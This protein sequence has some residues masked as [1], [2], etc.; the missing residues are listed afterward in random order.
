[1]EH[2]GFSDLNAKGGKGG[3]GAKPKDNYI[4]N[5]LVKVTKQIKPKIS[6]IISEEMLKS[7]N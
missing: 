6:E 3:K 4:T 5:L 2:L 1:M 7:L